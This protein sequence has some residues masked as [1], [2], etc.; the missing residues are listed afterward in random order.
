M[1]VLPG[2]WRSTDSGPQEVDL[3][4]CPVEDDGTTWVVDIEWRYV[5]KRFEPM[6][7]AVSCRSE[8]LRAVTAAVVARIPIGLIQRQARQTLQAYA[9]DV[10]TRR[11]SGSVPEWEASIA[12]EVTELAA[13]V[14][15][16]KRG[17]A[18][19]SA[20]LEAVA[21][22]Y[23]KAADT[24]FP[25]TAAVAEHFF[26]NASTAGKRI[27]RARAAGL[28]DGYENGQPT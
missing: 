13:A 26:I 27:M 20:D 17:S 8:P 1:H 25:V 7:V 19:T 28:L 21:A 18:L 12:D 4:I 22:V 24:G 5:G 3:Y 10:R 16:P 11:E 23:K 15:G 6:R 9:D 2:N 14:T